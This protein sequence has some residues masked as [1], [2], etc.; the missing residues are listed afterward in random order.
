[1]STSDVASSANVS[2]CTL[3]YNEDP[4]RFKRTLL[5]V[6]AACRRAAEDGLLGSVICAVGDNSASPVLDE[7]WLDE[8]R[9]ELADVVDLLDYVHFDSNLGFGGGMNR[10]FG[11]H[12]SAYVVFLNPDAVMTPTTM[13]SLLARLA[14]DKQIAIAEAKQMPLEH[15]KPFDSRSGDT[16]WATGACMAFRSSVFDELEGFD[17]SSFFMYCE[18]VDVSWRA[19][20][21]GYRVVLV[22]DAVLFHDKLLNDDAGIRPGDVEEYHGALSGLILTHKFGSGELVEERIRLVE[23]F[24]NERHKAGLAEFVELT[25]NGGLPARLE[26]A[27]RVAEFTGGEFAEHRW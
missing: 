10:L 3:L 16:P 1:M 22:P 13:S 7:A 6:G 23:K 20:L 8:V 26:G 12:P 25:Y 17:S 27:E 19:R 4:R 5:S 11:R 24:G 15:P 9:A 2:I 18:D 14:D 21:L